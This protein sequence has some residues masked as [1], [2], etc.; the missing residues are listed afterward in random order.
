M[1]NPEQLKFMLGVMCEGDELTK[2]AEM[3]INTIDVEIKCH[4]CGFE[5][6]GNVDDS[7]HYA[8]MILCPECESHRV[9]VINGKD[10]TVRSISIEK[11]DDEN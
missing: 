3:I 4:N 2:N 11:E 1:L 8:P 6:I 10:I 9:Q 7:D 5:G